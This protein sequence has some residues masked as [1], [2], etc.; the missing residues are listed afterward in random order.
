M[1]WLTAL[2]EWGGALRVFL[3]FSFGERVE[4]GAK[5]RFFVALV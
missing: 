4:I 2:E 5:L 1:R 3:G